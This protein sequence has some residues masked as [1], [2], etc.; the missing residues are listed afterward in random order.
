[1]DCAIDLGIEGVP[2]DGTQLAEKGLDATL[3][4]LRD[5]GL[6]VCQVGLFMFNPLSTDADGQAK[7]AQALE[8]ILPSL[9]D[10]GCRYVTIGPGNYHP[11]GFGHFDPRNFTDAAID[12]LAEGLKPVVDLAAKHDA[13]LTI[14]AYLKGVIHSPDRFKQ[15]HAKVGGDHLK[16]NVDPTSLYDFGDMIDPSAKVESTCRG[17]AGHVGLVH[18]KEVGIDEGFHIHMGLKPIG[19]G[20]TDWGR[21][22][23]LVAPHVPADSWVIVEHVES[24]AEAKASMEQV[25]ALVRDLPSEQV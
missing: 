20:P 24:P 21:L 17:L 4:P 25:R 12:A 3:A 23:G 5:H 8:A 13:V 14:E 15:L 6:A 11:S 2:I 19:E 16:C 1:L 7:Q 10:V 22:L 18:L 9:R